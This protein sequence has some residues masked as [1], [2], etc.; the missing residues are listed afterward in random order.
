MIKK[1]MFMILLGLNLFGCGGDNH[2]PQNVSIKDNKNVVNT[3]QKPN[4][5]QTPIIHEQRNPLKI[6]VSDELYTNKNIS[7][8]AYIPNEDIIDYQWKQLSGNS[9]ELSSKKQGV[10]NFETH[11]IGNY[12]FQVTVKTISNAVYQ[13]EI[14]FIVKDNLNSSV[15]IL[16]DRAIPA[17]RMF[18]MEVIGEQDLSDV[19]IHNSESTLVAS[20]I[21]KNTGKIYLNISPTIQQ[22]KV[23][24]IQ[25]KKNNTIIDTAQILVERNKKASGS[26]FCTSQGNNCVTQQYL[27]R[28]FPYGKSNYTDVLEECV[29]SMALN[30]QKL[31][32]IDKLPPIVLED[33]SMAINTIMSRVLVSEEWMGDRFRDFLLANS[34]HKD[35]QELLKPV[36]A[37][38]I[39]ENIKVPF[40]WALTGAIYLSPY[41]FYLNKNEKLSISNPYDYH[42]FIANNAPTIFLWRYVKNNHDIALTLD[43]IREKSSLYYN[44]AS[45]MYH[46]L[47]HANDY[48]PLS[49]INTFN[50]SLPLIDNIATNHEL[51]SSQMS[52]LYPL[53]S[54]DLKLIALYNFNRTPIDNQILNIE[55]SILLNNLIDDNASD[56]YNYVDNKEDL[57]MIFEETMMK[58][59]Y[60]IDREIG[61]AKNTGSLDE[62]MLVGGQKNRIFAP[63]ISLKAQFI[64]AHLLADKSMNIN[65]FL[66]K[67]KEK[68]LCLGSSWGSVTYCENNR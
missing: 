16:R 57:A 15:Q 3:H 2:K 12:T 20:N 40:Y 44:I 6:S 8:V 22:N 48:Y 42:S 67:K 52:Y 59:R 24:T 49:K 23:I 66:N 13:K 34:H 62:Y 4:K 54:N 33:N 21:D 25:L 45:L 43:G 26:Y 64:V 17:G 27:T 28:V 60:D 50:K 47:A 32:N 46:E 51:I 39:S 11:Q 1:Y 19:S 18:E 35:F 30:R 41:D 53:K 68:Y 65:N 10:V 38:V 55:S 63:N 31:C 5:T 9:V 14:S 29:F 56:L 7:L 58:Y 37:I 36:T 61:V